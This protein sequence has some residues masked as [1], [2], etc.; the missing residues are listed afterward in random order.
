M[1][2]Y[3]TPVLLCVLEGVTRPNFSALM[4]LRNALLAPENQNHSQADY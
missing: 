3:A 2:V 4:R 1:V